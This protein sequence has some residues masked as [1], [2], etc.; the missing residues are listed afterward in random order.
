VGAALD[1][2][3]RLASKKFGGERRFFWTFAVNRKGGRGFA[4]E[5]EG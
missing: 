2:S 1:S 3:K 4:L 5:D